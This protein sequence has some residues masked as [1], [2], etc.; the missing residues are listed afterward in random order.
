MFLP[1]RSCVCGGLRTE[2]KEAPLPTYFEGV[3][4][5]WICCGDGIGWGLR[6]LEGILLVLMLFAVCFA[7]FHADSWRSRSSS[8]SLLKSNIFGFKYNSFE[9]RLSRLSSSLWLVSSS[10]DVDTLS[11]FFFLG[12][13]GRWTYPGYG[14]TTV[15]DF[16]NL[17]GLF[18]RCDFGEVNQ[19][20]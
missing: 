16:F 6:K 2:E 8:F 17:I 1:G 5:N 3:C 9:F 11:R 15:Q 7:F 4:G 20:K 14:F 19:T 13:G 12:I 18:A 10:S